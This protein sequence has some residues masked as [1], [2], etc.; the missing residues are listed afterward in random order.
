MEYHGKY[1]DKPE[2]D[3][4][5]AYHASREWVKSMKSIGLCKNTID[6]I[7]DTMYIALEVDYGE[8]V[9]EKIAE[10]YEEDE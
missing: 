3:A 6:H 1:H 10:N 2:S 5:N 9:I 7:W 4:Y 8:D